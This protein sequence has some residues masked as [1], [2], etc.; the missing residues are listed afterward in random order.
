MSSRK[1][2]KLVKDRLTGRKSDPFTHILWRRV[3][4]TDENRKIVH[5][6]IVFIGKH[7]MMEIRADVEIMPMGDLAR[8][9]AELMDFHNREQFK[10]ALDELAKW[11]GRL[12]QSPLGKTEQDF[13]AYYLDVVDL[14]E[15]WFKSHKS[16]SK[17]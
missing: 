1:R 10:R 13:V 15:K 6:D 4:P 16:H 8:T 12:N 7:G 14:F 3:I 9:N 2:R 17:R 5:R 11:E